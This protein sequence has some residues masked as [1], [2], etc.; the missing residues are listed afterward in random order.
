MTTRVMVAALALLV[1]GC[2]PSPP[3][4]NAGVVELQNKIAAS[5]E[6][7]NAIEQDFNRASANCEE[8]G[9]VKFSDK[10]RAC[11]PKRWQ[12]PKTVTQ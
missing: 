10:W 8:K 12:E 5:H 7:M 9:F 6:R 11:M 2:S 1:G 3:A 4:P